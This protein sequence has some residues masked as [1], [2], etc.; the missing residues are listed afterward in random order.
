MKRVNNLY[1]KIADSDNLYLA[2]YKAA[3]GKQDRRE[4]VE[5]RADFSANINHLRQQLLT[6]S[7]LLCYP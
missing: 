5:F 4:V 6:G 3:K 2:F 1:P 7:P